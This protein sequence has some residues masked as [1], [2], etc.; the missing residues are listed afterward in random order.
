MDAINLLKQ[1]H[2]TVEKLFHEF[3]LA[4]GVTDQEELCQRICTQLE[5]HSALEEQCFYPGVRSVAGMDDKV[6]ES[7]REHGE[8]KRLCGQLKS[9]TARDS[10]LQSCMTEL[11]QAVEHHVKEEEQEMFPNVREACDQQ[12]LLGI[13]QAME[14]QKTQL[15]SQTP[16]P[17]EQRVREDVREPSREHTRS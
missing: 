4:K 7:L 11:K 15:Q 8:V 9:M 6:D 13:A 10:Q 16:A 1:D 12:W 2:R 3:Q 17:G 14:Q 5:V